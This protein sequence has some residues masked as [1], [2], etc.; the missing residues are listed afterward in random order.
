[1]KI[2]HLTLGLRSGGVAQVVY[3]LGKDQVERGNEVAVVSIHHSSY[4]EEPK[5]FEEI[6]IKVIQRVLNSRFDFR[7]IVWLAKEMRKYD[8]VHVHLFPNQLYAPIALRLIPAKQRP[9][10]ITTEHNTWNNRRNYKQ[11]RVVD[12]WMY[13]IYDKIVAISPETNKS[14]NNWLES[15]KLRNKIITINNGI[16]IPKFKNAPDNLFSILNIP[17]DSICIGMVCRMEAPK[18]PATLIR[19][20]AKV[21]GLHII[22][23]GDG[24]LLPELKRLAESL[25][26]TNRC[27]F[28]GNQKNVAQLLKGL[29]IGCLS[30][31]W[32]GFGLV[33]VEYMAAGLP[34]WVSDV[35]GLREVVG[36]KDALFPKG[37]HE[38]LEEKIQ[39]LL[40]DEDY[41]NKKKM[42]SNER[43]EDFSVIKTA[44]AYWSLYR[45][46]V[47]DF[48]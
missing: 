5:R 3:D 8:L 38:I 11:L 21:Q 9:K 31:D 43:C 40:T 15:D 13:G 18:D 47:K 7:I 4:K 30:T 42:Y 26:M 12:R 14:L 19:A 2:L 20:G 23:I 44:D 10:L 27:H 33:A 24:P 34:V 36:D 28:L 16:E 46:L 41:Y 17:A 25:D 32:D 6:G 22:L 39:K 37:N 48:E 45:S 29:K 35:V 1:M